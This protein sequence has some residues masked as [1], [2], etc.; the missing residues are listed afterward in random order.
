MIRDAI[1]KRIEDLS[2]SQRKC[3]IESGVDYKNFNAFLKGRRPFPFTLSA[4]SLFEDTS[5][6]FIR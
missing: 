1:I 2:V 5:L 3:A 4:T 6:I